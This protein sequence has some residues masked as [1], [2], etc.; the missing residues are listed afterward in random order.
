MGF[1][2]QGIA[3]SKK[4]DTAQKL[5]DTIGLG[6]I[7]KVSDNYFEEASSSMI[8]DNDIYITEVKN[9]TIVTLGS[10]FDIQEIALNNASEQGKAIKFM[11]GE[12]SMAFAFE[13]FLNGQGIRT[14]L[15][16]EG[17]NMMEE[18][19]PLEIETKESDMTEIIF[20]LIGDVTGNSFYSIE[21]DQKSEHFRQI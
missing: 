8:D 9:G 4:Y 14:I 5:A 2:V 3:I 21:P 1:N 10:A 11:V 17:E 13:Y 15:N 19:E 7:E 12:T 18:G 20:S 16:A 6:S